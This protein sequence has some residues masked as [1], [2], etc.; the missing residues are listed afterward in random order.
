MC[1]YQWNS[2]DFL[3]FE[4]QV[5]GNYSY[6]NKIDDD[7]TKELITFYEQLILFMKLGHGEK[8]IFEKTLLLMH[9]F[10]KK[11]FFKADLERISNWAQTITLL[12]YKLRN[13]DDCQDEISPV[14]YE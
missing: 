4:K 12:E 9:A 14:A 2:D 7:S 11:N 10:G 1:D 5:D 13:S 8:D 3:H 6:L